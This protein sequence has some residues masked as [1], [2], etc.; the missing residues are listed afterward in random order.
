MS[1]LRRDRVFGFFRGGNVRIAPLQVLTQNEGKR[2]NIY[3]LGN[4]M[5]I[6]REGKK[7]FA[8]KADGMELCNE[9]EVEQRQDR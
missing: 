9:K 4:G 1:G 2:Y 7:P 8:L 5:K 3:K 6:W